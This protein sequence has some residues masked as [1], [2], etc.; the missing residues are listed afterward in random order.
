MDVFCENC[1][2]LTAKIVDGSK[3]RKDA[4]MLC[5]NCYK[6][7]KNAKRLSETG[8]KNPFSDLFGNKLFK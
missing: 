3:I 5:D 2:K 6:L 8:I 1:R 4:V 7:L